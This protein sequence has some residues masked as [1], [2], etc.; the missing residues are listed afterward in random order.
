MTSVFGKISP[1]FHTLRAFLISRI[2]LT[3]IW[4]LSLAGKFGCC[5]QIQSS[6]PHTKKRDTFFSINFGCLNQFASIQNI[7]NGG[8]Y[9]AVLWMSEKSNNSYF[10]AGTSK[11]TPDRIH[12]AHSP[13]KTPL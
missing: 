13:G 11:L 7:A 8:R 6:K 4:T 1:M 5:H 2:L 12:I 9:P 3:T 10:S